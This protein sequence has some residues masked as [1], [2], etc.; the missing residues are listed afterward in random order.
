MNYKVPF[1]DLSVPDS[2]KRARYLQAID[3]VLQHGRILLGPEVNEL[4]EKLAQ[5]CHRK[6]AIGVG[7]GTDALIIAL[8]AADIGKGDEVILG[9][10]SWI[11]SATAIKMVGASPVFVDVNAHGN[12][13]PG[14]V[15]K[16]ISPRT[17][18]IL[19]VNYSGKI[20][21]MESLIE[22]VSAHQLLLIEDA[23]QAFGAMRKG[24]MAGS[25]GIMSCFSMNP[26]K[27][28]GAFGEAGAV[29]TDSADLRNRLEE[30]R[31]NGMRNRTVSIQPSI[32]ARIDT[33]HAAT[34]LLQLD[35]FQ[36]NIARRREIAGLYD[37][38]IADSVLKPA[39]EKDCLDTYFC[40]PI[41]VKD[42]DRVMDALT[43]SGIEC[44][45]REWDY[46]PDHP[47]MKG[48]KVVSS[49]NA[50]M[51][52]ESMICLPIYDKLLNDQVMYVAE[53][54]NRAVLNS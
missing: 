47:S 28:F 49:E 6:Y 4:E 35:E 18:A 1:N 9:A 24:H 3:R 34:L 16:A 45:K 12:I 50:R 40:Y 29:M 52:S 53:E 46:L 5:F 19:T 36:A 27:V 14:E 42:R 15:A 38:H 41:R 17:K 43:R 33:I 22:I 54:V 10:M 8:L 51:F 7:S 20:A 37:R 32:N 48:E 13:S 23:A 39:Q 26:M 11:A 30:L 44:K 21:E 25:Y 2:G 31:Y